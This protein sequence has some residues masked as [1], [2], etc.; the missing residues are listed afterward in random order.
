ML[1]FFKNV[2]RF[3]LPIS[4]GD[5]VSV[6]KDI[7]SAAERV[8]TQLNEIGSSFPNICI[9]IE[10]TKNKNDLKVAFGRLNDAMLILSLVGP[11]TEPNGIVYQVLNELKFSK[12]FG[13]Y[14]HTA[15]TPGEAILGYK[16]AVVK[17]VSIHY[18]RIENFIKLYT[19]KIMF[20]YILPPHNVVLY[21]DSKIVS[22]Q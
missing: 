20:F 16:T 5:N 22:L 1:Y 12:K 15:A 21:Q 8:R 9:S 17:E 13:F 14:L 4:D 18:R 2:F 6:R 11:L 10:E 3:F 7:I 19:S